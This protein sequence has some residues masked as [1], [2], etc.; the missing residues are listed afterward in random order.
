ML[1]YIETLESFKEYQISKIIEQINKRLFAALK[2][3]NL[4]PKIA[5]YFAI[6][7]EDGP[8]FTN[9]ELDPDHIS[10]I[11]KLLNAL[12]YARL[13]FID[14]EAIDLRV[15]VIHTAG[16]LIF[17]YTQTID[18]LYEACYLGTHWDAD[19]PDLFYQEIHTLLPLVL[20]LKKFISPTTEKTLG[21]TT[22]ED[23]ARVQPP[24]P[25]PV[26]EPKQPAKSL[27]ELCAPYS[28]WGGEIAGMALEQM[29]PSTGTL[30]YNFLT[31]FSATLPSYIDQTTELIKNYSKQLRT[32]EPNL[33]PEQLSEL[34]NTALALLN[35]LKNLNSHSPFL[36]LKV[37]NYIHI[38]RHI[39]TLSIST[40]EQMG[41]LSESSQDAI[42]QYLGQ[43]KYVALPNLFGLVDNIELNCMLKP[44]TLS[45]PLMVK[46]KALYQTLTYYAAKPVDFTVKGEELLQIEDP[47]FQAL[48]LEQ[49]Y[50]RIDKANISLF[51]LNK[52]QEALE[53]FYSKLSQAYDQRLRLH[54]LPEEIKAELRH[55][56]IL[57]KPYMSKI[58]IDNTAYIP[59]FNLD[60]IQQALKFF[61]DKLSKKTDEEP[62]LDDWPEEEKREIQQYYILLTHY[63][64]QIDTDISDKTDSPLFNLDKIQETLKLF[65]DKLSPKTDPEFRLHQL[66]EEERKP[67]QRLYALLKPYMGEIDAGSN[68]VIVNSLLGI[69]QTWADGLLTRWRRF[70][71]KLPIDHLQLI[72]QTKK[73]LSRFLTKKIKS[74]DFQIELNTQLIE[75]VQKQTNL[76]LYPYAESINVFT[77][78]E[79]AVLTSPGLEFTTANGNRF[80]AK[81]EL[82][83]TDDTL[84]LYQWYRNKRNKFAAAKKAYDALSEFLNQ[85]E[86]DDH[87]LDMAQLTR[88]EKEQ[89]RRWYNLF[90]PYFIHGVPD[91][92]KKAT[93]A[94]DKYL[95][96]SF[97]DDL[98][99]RL[100]PMPNLLEKLNEHFQA[101]F[102]QIDR[103]WQE[104]SKFYL[105][106]AA[107]KF[108]ASNGGAQLVPITDEDRAHYLIKHTHYSQFAHEFRLALQGLTV[109]FNKTMKNELQIQ[110]SGI[111]FPELENT[112]LINTQ[113]EQVF[114]IKQIYNNFYHI[115]GIVRSLEDLN[116]KDFKS[117]YVYNLLRI[118]THI[119][120]IV[121]A[122]QQLAKDPHF[123]LIGNYLTKKVQNIWS[124]IVEHVAPY[125][126]AATDVTTTP[127][128]VQYNALWYVLNAL[129][130]IPRH[131]RS[132]KDNTFLSNRELDE[133]HASAKESAVIIERI[134]ECSDSYFKLF[135]ESPK[136]LHLY[137]ELKNKLFEIVSTIHHTS[138]SQLDQLNASVFAPMLLEADLWEDRM[139]LIPGT[140]SGPMKTLLDEFHKGLLKPLKLPS[141]T[142]LA[143][144][145]DKST[146]EIRKKQASTTVETCKQ[147]LSDLDKKYHKINQLYIL[148]QEYNGLVSTLIKSPPDLIME[149]KNKIIALYPQVLHKL[150]TLKNQ[151]QPPRL[152]EKATLETTSFDNLLNATL[153]E[154]DPK[155]SHISALVEASHDFYL[156]RKKTYEIRL[157]SSQEKIQYLEELDSIQ[158]GVNDLFTNQYTLD[159]FNRQI[160]TLCS[161]YIGLQF[162]DEEYNTRLTEHVLMFQNEITNK[163]KTS[164]DINLTIEQLLKEKISAFETI[165]CAQYHQL[166][167]I[168]AALNQFKNYFSQAT[169]DIQQRRPTIESTET[170]NRKSKQ[171]KIL[172]DIA[173][174][175]DNDKTTPIAKRIAKIKQ[176]VTTN[177]IFKNTMLEQ[178]Q[179]DKLSLSYLRQCFLWLLE[180]LHLY[181]PQSKKHFNHLSQAVTY[182]PQ[183]T[184]L[185][186]HFGLFASPTTAQATEEP[187]T[188]LSPIITPQPV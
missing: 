37:I 128:A 122:S 95:A 188:N 74:Q 183:L 58:D 22:T 144:I 1:E 133:L 173:H 53:M 140:L 172:V 27:V 32:K 139:G 187:S 169:S 61:H 127:G 60:K 157:N 30:D 178:K 150:V 21:T 121:V 45:V 110:A 17:L 6:I 59:P 113:G 119:N 90:Q 141:K 71:G 101:H 48:R 99:P 42:R 83:S 186:K 149:K 107:E 166:D 40:L 129:Y 57:L 112:R 185:T 177:P 72:L 77:M 87:R 180:A 31:Q 69:P 39:I 12:Y 120:H 11:K 73:P 66:P 13:A 67:L 64:S 65:H 47:R 34:E 96:R 176:T 56:Y 114:A 171:I 52:V 181:T 84:T 81:P 82:L 16:D 68:E 28:N 24:V 147:Q 130:I 38:I 2:H 43:L 162:A 111:P 151:L 98:P 54:E 7:H 46:I 132:L 164:E 76:I 158:N 4:N 88:A 143:L 118:Y 174:D 126:T 106:L 79:S 145:H 136:M 163:A 33:N 15:N 70:Q 51:K 108:K 78:D 123:S 161:R 167:A 105:K 18:K 155:L 62:S 165:Y 124:N 41:Y 154:Y 179:V 25:T 184:E 50:Q 109:H 92:Q 94:F 19:L 159:S 182:T 168:M 3:P 142:H 125:Q 35:D 80:V 5:P 170:L 152:N 36:P 117:I 134:V 102:T 10:Q 29:Q 8:P 75:S 20:K 138:I 156:K 23:T 100:A 44:G 14:L 146:I 55:H 137:Q 115:E 153:N 91:Q 26:E 89:C 148:I 49:T 86:N 93:L 135:L 175:L 63:M 9:Y 103:L 97:A 104:K 160:E 85:H 131:I 116:E